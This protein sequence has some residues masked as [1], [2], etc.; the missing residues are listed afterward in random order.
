MRA[1][2]GVRVR[3][4]A[5]LAA[6]ERTDVL[7]DELRCLAEHDRVDRPHV[8]HVA[9]RRRGAAVARDRLAHHRVGDVVLAET[10]VFLRYR[11]CEE[12]VLTEDLQVPA[13]ERELVVES[14]GVGPK[15]RLAELDD[16]RSE[17]LLPVGEHPVGVPLVP[18]APE[19]LGSPH[20]LGHGPTSG[21]ASNALGDVTG[22]C[23]FA[24]PKDA[25]EEGRR[26]A[27]PLR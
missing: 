11:Q 12:T 15:L 27:A 19:R 8:H 6:V 22:A 1:R 18:E 5:Q 9:H 7:V 26:H 10:A 3:Q 16:R 24:R 14:L 25:A 2:L 20:L 4:G 23:G 21:R 13:R 17:L